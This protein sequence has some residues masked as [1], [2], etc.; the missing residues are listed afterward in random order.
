MTNGTGASA[1]TFTLA[2]S[3]GNGAITCTCQP[4]IRAAAAVAAKATSNVSPPGA[5]IGL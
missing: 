1:S 3:T 5:L 2:S 4:I